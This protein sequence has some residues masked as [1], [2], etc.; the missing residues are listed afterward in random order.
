[1]LT[2]TGDYI[3]TYTMETNLGPQQSDQTRNLQVL[4]ARPIFL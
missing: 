1:M 3:F 4:F 2:D